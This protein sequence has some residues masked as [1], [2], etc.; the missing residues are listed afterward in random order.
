MTSREKQVPEGRRNA[1]DFWLNDH[2]LTLPPLIGES[3]EAAWGFWLTQ[4]PSAWT[5]WSPGAA[6]ATMRKWLESNTD[7]PLGRIAA[8]V[9]NPDCRPTQDRRPDAGKV[10]PAAGEVR[11]PAR[12]GH[13]G[14]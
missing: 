8:E 11:R 6:E 14:Q 12:R 13:G 7:K 3:I 4:H 2:T 9:A 5:R 10:V 1:S